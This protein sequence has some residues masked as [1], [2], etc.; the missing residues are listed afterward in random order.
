M[1]IRRRDAGKVAVLEAAGQLAG[2]ADQRQFHDTIRG[3]VAE[4]RLEVL[5][6]LSRLTRLNS[7]GLGALVAGYHTVARA[8][9]RLKLCAVNDRIDSILAGSGL[10]SVFEVFR[11]E[12][13]ALVAFARPRV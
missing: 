7:T 12:E 3:L 1:R 2:A 13:E 6:D 10:Y 11:T 4:G 8:G 9:G 5:I